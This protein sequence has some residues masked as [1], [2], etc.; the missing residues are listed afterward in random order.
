M[1]KTVVEL[2]LKGYGDLARELEEHLSAETV[3]EFNQQLQRFVDQGLGAIDVERSDAVMA[4][5][6]DGAILV[7]DKAAQAHA[8]AVALHD[9]CR[10]HNQ[11]KTL[12]RAMRWFRV[13][14]ATG[15][16]AMTSNQEGHRIG[17][18]VITRAVRLETAAGIGEVLADVETYAGLSRETQAAYGPEESVS[19]KGTE[20]Y[21]A[22]RLV[23]V[24]GLDR[25]PP[26]GGSSKDTSGP[27]LEI[28]KEKLL[29]FE[30]ELAITASAPARFELRFRIN[31]TLEG[32]RELG[33]LP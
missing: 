26:P 32:I 12:A 19:G 1:I 17:G 27:A 4:T 13:G 20:K 16:L 15:E 18:S 30:K 8:F 33:G 14:I 22:R 3:L 9:A 25:I 23:V 10:R 7:F 2:D 6:G 31:E 24:A 5:T 28:L 29:F 11:Q 21:A